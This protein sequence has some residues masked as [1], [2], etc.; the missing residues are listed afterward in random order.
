MADWLWLVLFLAGYVVLMRW[1]RRAHLNCQLMP[2]RGSARSEGQCGHTSACQSAPSR[3][4]NNVT[5]RECLSPFK[6]LHGKMRNERT[7]IP[8]QIRIQQDY[9]SLV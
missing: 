2:R 9:Q 5:L 6:P 4:V 1:L 7:P 8:K 3:K